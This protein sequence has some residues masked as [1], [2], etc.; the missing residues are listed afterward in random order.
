[1]T[2][3]QQIQKEE[4]IQNEGNSNETVGKVYE[5]LDFFLFSSFFL[6]SFFFFFILFVVRREGGFPRVVQNTD[7]VPSILIILTF[8]VKSSKS[9]EMIRSF[10]K[11]SF[12]QELF[13][14]CFLYITS[15]SKLRFIINHQ[16][17]SSFLDTF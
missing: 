12:Y 9:Y 16:Y 4:L 1:M 2:A 6:F 5:H 10:V 15:Q 7:N 3:G 11:C 14:P 8:N 13:L 17:V